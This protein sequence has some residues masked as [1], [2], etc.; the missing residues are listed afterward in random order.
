MGYLRRMK[1]YS[2]AIALILIATGCGQTPQAEQPL[3]AFL[4]DGNQNRTPTY[5][6]GIAFWEAMAAHYK[7]VDMHAYGMT[8][9][10]YPLHVVIVD[11]DRP[12][13]IGA[14]K[15]GVKQLVLINNAIHPGESDGVDASMV[16]VH[17]LLNSKKG[18][19]LLEEVSLAIIPFYNIG[20]AL[21]R[22]TSSRANQN[23]PESYGFRGNAQNLDLNRDFVK[24]DSRNAQ[25]F[26]TL[27]NE[28][29]PDLYLETHVSNGAD[30]Q[31]TI[32]YI[33]TQEDKLG[34]TL[35]AKLRDDWTPFIVDQIQSTGFKIGPYVN[36][37]GAPPDN[38]FAAFYDSPRYSSGYLA[39]RQTPGYII[40]TH[41]L[42]P[43]AKRV[44]ATKYFLLASL[45]MVKKFNVRQVVDAS[46][47]EQKTQQEFVLDWAIDSSVNESLHFEGYTYEYM[48]SDL[49]GGQRLKYHRD[50]PFTKSVPYWN[51]YKPTIMITAPKYYVLKRG[52]VEVEQRLKNMGVE[53]ISLERD[54]VL[55]AEVYHIASFETSQQPFEKHYYHYNSKVEVV[56]EEVKLRKGDYIIPLDNLNR[57]AIVEVL[58]PEGP[59]SYF[60]WNFFDA[61]LQQKEWF[62]PYVFED[63]AKELLANNAEL[64]E[65]F[66][67]WVA[68]GEYN[69]FEKLY[70]VYKHSSRYERE[71][72]RY[73]VFRVMR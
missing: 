39:L 28:M 49:T 67:N 15:Q 38:G 73:P 5:E 55:R 72:L 50:Q 64:K 23:G 30:Y 6:E 4:Q 17:E 51:K 56:E 71:H 41:M 40:E 8:D 27:I 61:I 65:A 19:Q 62:S 2:L 31:Y 48:P 14:Y 16:L 9:A 46:R 47:V 42:K 20:G 36:V 25:S 52:F 13:P 58:E 33:P 24:C 1:F 3:P 29:D 53:L 11:G 12:R 22:N 45:E 26:A 70:W 66:D 34:A 54:T 21:N 43:Y 57:R 32:T 44:E 7:E 35:G 68:S 18:K 10:G 63:E 60:N 69:A 37:H 59:D